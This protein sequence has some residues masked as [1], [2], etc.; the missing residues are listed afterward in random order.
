MISTS[1]ANNG[2]VFTAA[3]L[4]DLIIKL[5]ISEP[6]LNETQDNNLAPDYNKTDSNTTCL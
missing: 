1:A 2:A 3:Q 5:V 4:N 6:Y